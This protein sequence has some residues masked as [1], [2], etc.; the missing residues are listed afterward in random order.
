MISI[1]I[2]QI[3]LPVE[4]VTLYLDAGWGTKDN[5]VNADLI[6]GKAFAYSHFITAR[7]GKKL[8]GMIRFL[9]DEAHDTQVIECV[10]LKAYQ[11]RGIGTQMVNALIQYYGA[12][13][14]YIQTTANTEAF[15]QKNNFKKHH[16][17]GLSYRR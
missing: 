2:N 10:V 1:E 16:L 17:I 6:F 12:T 9:S 5:Y 13:D 14:I 11:G 4:A 3:P 8:V 7:E 15:F